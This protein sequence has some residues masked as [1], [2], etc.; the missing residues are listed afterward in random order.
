M[1]FMSILVGVMVIF[2]IVMVVLSVFFHWMCMSLVVGAVIRKE[3]RRVSN[4]C[5]G[6]GAVLVVCFVGL[7]AAMLVAVR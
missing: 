7:F 6:V 3:N 4:V 5:L 1:A 2:I